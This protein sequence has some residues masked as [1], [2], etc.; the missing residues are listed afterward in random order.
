MK[1]RKYALP[2]L[3]LL[4]ALLVLGGCGKQ[5]GEGGGTAAV[6]YAPEGSSDTAIE[7]ER[8][9]LTLEENYSVMNLVDKTTGEVWSSLPTDKYFDAEAL[10]PMWRMRTS[11]LFQL[12][13]TNITSGLGVIVNSPLLQMDYTAAGCLKDGELYVSYD[14]AQPSIRLTLVFSLEE[15]GFRVRIPFDGIEEYGTQFSIVNLAILP[16]MSGATDAADGY[17]LYPDGSGAIMEFQDIAHIGESSYSYIVYGDVQNYER[18]LLP[19][20]AETPYAMLPVYG[21]NINDRGYIAILTQGDANARISVSCST[22][23][24]AVNGLYG[25][26]LYRQ[27]FK[28]SRVKTS[29]VLSYAGGIIPGDREIYY[30]F[31]ET[32]NTDYNAMAA[33]YRSYL[34]SRGME[35]GRTDGKYPLFLDVLMGIEEEGLL[36][37]E[38]Q[39]VT[40]F[41]QAKEM[42]EDLKNQG[43][44]NL[45]VNLKGYTKHGYFSEPNSFRI[46][47]SLGGKSGLK[48]F[49]KTAGE[50]NVPVTLDYHMLYAWDRIGGFSTQRDIIY[51]GNYAALTDED[52]K[53]FLLGPDAALRK[54]GKFDKK[55][56]KYDI[57]GYSLGG[58]GDTLAYSYNARSRY[59][60]SQ[61]I[62]E[63]NGLL[64]ELTDKYKVLALDGG[65]AYVLGYADYL[66][67][68]PAKDQ[69]FRFTTRSVPF[70]QLVVHGL[71]GY[72][73]QA[74]NLSGDLAG[75]KLKWVEYGYLPYF[76]LTSEGSESLMYTEYNELFTSEYDRWKG[77]VLEVYEELSDSV[78]FLAQEIITEHISLGGELYRVTYGNGT[79]IYINYADYEQTADGITIPARDYVVAAD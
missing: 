38:W 70:Y 32:G 68:I 74:G 8:Y 33:N 24:V 79:R 1:K 47:S 10:N 2:F 17:Y 31:L 52:E 76:E 65:N 43:V 34:E 53:L 66:K 22:K 29:T 46:N 18:F 39:Q 58:I 61:V 11:S 57:S 12:G 78:G 23:M 41:E 35:Y 4:T 67:N 54:F 27:G 36:F 37:D 40:D 30:R 49:L 71:A 5:Q 21:V 42:T 45:V 9:R 15:D 6:I 62:S 50:L 26:F 25:E 44:D 16:Y 48:N 56:E 60:S 51:L 64:A 14:L 7:N 73:M 77:E 55:V 19:F 63:W 20:E 59:N 75:E 13:Y 72:T 28:D 3:I 69:G